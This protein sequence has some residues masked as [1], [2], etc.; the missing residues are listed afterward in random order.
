MAA[1]PLKPQEGLPKLTNQLISD[2]QHR[3]LEPRELA[4]FLRQ[5]AALREAGLPA[6]SQPPRLPEGEDPAVPGGAFRLRRRH[7]SAPA[8]RCVVRAR[9][10]RHGAH[11]RA[12]PPKRSAA[13]A[14]SPARFPAP[15]GGQLFLIDRSRCGRFRNDGLSYERKRCGGLRE[16]HETLKGGC[17]VG[18]PGWGV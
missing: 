17:R 16:N 9:P 18:L 13:R 1:S 11:P 7:G 5:A 2:A 10:A 12:L 6:A 14:R 8:R 3:W 15:P 4:Q